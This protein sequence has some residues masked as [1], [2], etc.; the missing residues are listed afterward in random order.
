MA[1]SIEEYQAQLLAQKKRVADAVVDGRG[2][3]RKGRLNLDL[4]SLSGFLRVRVV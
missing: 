1:D 3:N 4:Q 2:I